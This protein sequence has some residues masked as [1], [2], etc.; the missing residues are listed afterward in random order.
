MAKVE[1]EVMAEIKPMATLKGRRLSPGSGRC[2]AS[3][4]LVSF[5]LLLLSI[6]L[7]LCELFSDEVGVDVW[8]LEE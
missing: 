6:N 2:S 7:H 4:S 8:D 1:K 3:W 5:K